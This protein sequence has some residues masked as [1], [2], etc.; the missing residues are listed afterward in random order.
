VVLSAIIDPEK[1]NDILK[2]PLF[3]R[4]L[5][6]ILSSYRKSLIMVFLGHERLRIRALNI[7]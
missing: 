5:Q 1:M 2:I 3:K 6:G 4:I 7:P